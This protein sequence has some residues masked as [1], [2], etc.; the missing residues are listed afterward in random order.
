MTPLQWAI[1][2]CTILEYLHSRNPL[3]LY[4]DMKPSNIM[5]RKDDERLFLIDFGIARKVQSTLSH[6]TSWGT[7]GYAPLEQ[8]QG[9]PEVRSDLYSLGATMHHLLSGKPPTPFKFDP[10]GTLRPDI[11]ASL[12]EV[13][14]RSLRLQAHERFESARK[15]REALEGK[16]VAQ[17][18]G[19]PAKKAG[20]PVAIA[21][22]PAPVSPLPSVMH[23]KKD[24]AETVLVPAGEFLMG[25]PSGEG[26][27][28]ECPRREVYLDAYHIY[29]HPVTNGQFASFVKETGYDA[30]GDWKKYALPGKENHPVVAVTWNDAQAYCKWAEGALPTEAQWE[31]AARGT[32]G[33]NYP[34]GNTWDDSKCNWYRGPKVAGMA[35]LYGGRGTTPVGS[36]PSG[37]SPWGC[38]D[39][40]GNVWEWCSDWYEENY[41]KSSPSRN[42]EGPPRGQYRVCRGGSW[43]NGGSRNVRCAYRGWGLPGNGANDVGFRV[44]RPSNTK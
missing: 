25:S 43:C 10:I 1:T 33:R 27:D 3:I 22:S 31:K 18:A 34:W 14:D 24:G 9:A 16:V 6:R 30:E 15:M 40:A 12:A 19:A 28:S 38:L 7:E 4:R 41:Y 26:S 39:V 2:I 35:N 44:C 20:A 21:Q 42:P 5:I 32:D 36:F 29:K 13:V 8:C 17:K 37:V 11:S 23:N